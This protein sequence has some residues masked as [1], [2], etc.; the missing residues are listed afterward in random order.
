[1]DRQPAAG[2]GRSG[3]QSPFPA[4]QTSRP[5]KEHAVSIL[6]ISAHGRYPSPLCMATPAG[7]PP[8]LYSALYRRDVLHFC[9]VYGIEYKPVPGSSLGSAMLWSQS[10][11]AGADIPGSRRGRA[12]PS[13]AL[14]HACRHRPSRPIENSAFSGCTNQ[15]SG[16]QACRYTVP[17]DLPDTTDYSASC[18]AHYRPTTTTTAPTTV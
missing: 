1:M 3:S 13:C 14:S 2:S 11:N 6:H 10:M 9:T 16:Q 7:P 18:S 17:C 4:L 12:A 15:K 8:S 5:A